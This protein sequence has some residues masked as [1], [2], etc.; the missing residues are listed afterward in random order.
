MKRKAYISFWP[1]AQYSEGF[2][3]IFLSS[4]FPKESVLLLGKYQTLTQK[5]YSNRLTLCPSWI[6]TVCNPTPV[7]SHCNVD[8]FQ[9][10]E[11]QQD[12]VTMAQQIDISNTVSEAACVQDFTL[13]TNQT[14]FYL[15]FHL[16]CS[17]HVWPLNQI[18][19]NLVCLNIY[20]Y[21]FIHTIKTL[22]NMYVHVWHIYIYNTYTFLERERVL[23][24]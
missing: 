13:W 19:V 20:K 16:S 17:Q 22:L 2:N 23:V 21:R 11:Q 7:G 18:H 12:Q 10:R 9:R 5:P 1:L 3:W 15:E 4:Y 14:I 24:L 6:G 8:Y